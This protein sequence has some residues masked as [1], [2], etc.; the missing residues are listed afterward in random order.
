MMGESCTLSGGQFILMRIVMM[1]IIRND[2]FIPVEHKKGQGV[3][4]LGQ[5]MHGAMP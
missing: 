3:L 5:E 4:H 2:K 1:M